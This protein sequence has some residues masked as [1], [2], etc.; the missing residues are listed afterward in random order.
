MQRSVEWL[1]RRASVKRAGGVVAVL[2][3]LVLASVATAGPITPDSS[4][5]RYVIAVNDGGR[6]VARPGGIGVD[7]DGRL[8]L[9]APVELTDP[10]RWAAS[11]SSISGQA[12]PTL[13]F[14]IGA[15]NLSVDLV[16]FNF[17]FA[18]P[19]ALSG[20]IVGH[21]A[22]RYGLS[23]TGTAGVTI[24]PTGA[25]ILTAFERDTTAGGLG[26][27]NKG[28]DIGTGLSCTPPTSG[29]CNTS[30]PIFVGTNLFTGDLAYDLMVVNLGF[31]LTR[32]AVVTMTGFVEQFSPVQPV[33][34]PA[35]LL[36]LGC[37]ACGGGLANW[38]RRRE[39]RAR[40]RA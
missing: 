31:T 18:I 3:V 5:G 19:V 27:L 2:T 20:T 38:R 6:I 23:T 32:G 13:G 34:E 40:I 4:Y 21:S 8:Y 16:S 10:G 29:G 25:H 28:L 37:A 1:A 33:P 35:S 15:T 39:A 9:G 22:L 26:D 14:A 17:S 7:S 30:S 24:A 11:I 36:L 12:D